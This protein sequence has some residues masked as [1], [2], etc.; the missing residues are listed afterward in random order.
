MFDIKQIR[1]IFVIEETGMFD[2]KQTDTFLIM[3]KQ[4]EE[5]LGNSKTN[6]QTNA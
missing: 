3:H 5:M 6:K 4:K 1:H 2:I